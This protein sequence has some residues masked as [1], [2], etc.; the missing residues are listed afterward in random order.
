V[1]R[2]KWILRLTCPDADLIDASL[3][4]LLL[5]FSVSITE[6]MDCNSQLYK[7]KHYFNLQKLEVHL[8]EFKNSFP[9]A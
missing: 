5:G 2:A 4:T 1:K 6:L 8:N 7:A 3:I 9:A